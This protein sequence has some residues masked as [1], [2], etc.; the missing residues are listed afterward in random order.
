MS[1][2]RKKGSTR[3]S[4]YFIL[5]ITK[6]DRP[7]P[8]AGCSANGRRRITKSKHRVE[9]KSNYSRRS[10]CQATTVLPCLIRSMY[11]ELSSSATPSPMAVAYPRRSPQTL[12]RYLRWSMMC[13]AETR[14]QTSLTL[15]RLMSYIYIYIYIWSTHS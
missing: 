14:Q 4:Q 15:R 5:L 1:R 3:H 12:L 7:K 8:T 6:S 2:P 9:Q 11:Y 13:L 10:T